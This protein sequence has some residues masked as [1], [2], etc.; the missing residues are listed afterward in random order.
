MPDIAQDFSNLMRRVCD[1][2]PYAIRELTERYGPQIQRV[3]RRKLAKKLRSKFDSLD[4]VQDVWASFFA[5]PVPEGQF[6]RAEALIA[7]LT[8]MA[9][10]KVVETNRVRHGL[11]YEANREESLES[12]IPRDDELLH[13]DLPTAS[14]VAVA[15]ET[16]EQLLAGLPPHY[17]RIVELMRQGHSPQETARQLGLAERTV[18]RVLRKLAPEGSP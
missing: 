6:D 18:Y 11:K 12:A 13:D 8:A 9:H 1:G 5:N 10:N 2:C 14:Q 3:I 16:L 15:N 7:F 4:F 17:Q